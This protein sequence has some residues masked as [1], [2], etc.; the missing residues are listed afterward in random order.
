MNFNEPI[1]IK[2]SKCNKII[3]LVKKLFL[4]LSRKSLLTI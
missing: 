4:T 3:R 2:I 1:E